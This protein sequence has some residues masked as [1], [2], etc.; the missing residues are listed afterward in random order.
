MNE[1]ER[2]P[3]PH[4]KDEANA[5]ELGEPEHEPAETEGG[6]RAERAQQRPDLDE[7]ERR[8]STERKP[9]GPPFEEREGEAASG[10]EEE[11][12]APSDEPP[13]EPSEA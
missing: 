9:M 8:I 4:G 11:P 1:H 7:R 5:V 2:E 10:A 12:P 13:T 3:A 6:E